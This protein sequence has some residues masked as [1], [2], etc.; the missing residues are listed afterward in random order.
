MKLQLFMIQLHSIT[1]SSFM[2]W[3]NGFCLTD[4][5]ILLWRHVDIFEIL[6]DRTFS[7]SQPPG[8]IVRSVVSIYVSLSDVLDVNCMQW[9]TP[10]PMSPCTLQRYLPLLS[11]WCLQILSQDYNSEFFCWST[12]F[13]S[14]ADTCFITWLRKKAYLTST[15]ISIH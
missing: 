15:F 14:G 7:P 10:I 1:S 12:S 3:C 9:Q 8:C 6:S 13:S 5:I 2:S 4:K 11:C